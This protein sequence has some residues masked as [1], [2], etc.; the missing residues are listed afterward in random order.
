MQESARLFALLI[1]SLLVSCGGETPRPNVILV[2]VDDLGWADLSVYGSAYHETP[3]IDRLAEGGI[4]FTQAYAAAAV[5]SPSRAA[6]LTGRYP[7]RLGITD[8]IR[9]Q[10]QSTAVPPGEMPEPFVAHPSRK[11]RCP[12]NYPRLKLEEVT[13]AELMKEAGYT[14]AHIGKWHLG[15]EEWYPDDQGFDENYGG[16]DYGQ[17]PSYFDPYY[18]EGHGTI[19]TLP[20]RKEGEYLTDREA[21]EAVGFITKNADR[22]FFLYLAHY[23]VHTPIQAKPDVEAYYEGKPKTHQDNAAYAAMVQSVDDA[24]G[25]VLAALDSLGLSDDTL[26]LFTSDNGGLERVTDNAPLRDGKGSPYEGGIRVPLIARYPGVIEEGGESAFPAS[27]IDYLPTLVDLLS[28]NPPDA[29]I[30][31]T[32]L[33]PI[34]AGGTRPGR[35]QLLWHFP[36]YRGQQVGPYSI[37]RSGDWKMIRFYDAEPWGVD[38]IELFDL[39]ADPY[40]TTNVADVHRDLVSELEVQLDSLLENM[41]ARMPEPNPDYE[42]SEEPT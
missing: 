11:L 10:F 34:L 20:G 30:D 37:L 18:R 6:L 15:T 33:A 39:E 9:A 22:P 19:P 25:R 1:A 5:C 38:R 21:D 41:G 23:A 42:L 2:H 4:R 26:I 36:H 8:W 16:C 32:S 40:E 31:G 17:P 13:I 12:S 14:T 3:H 7:A 27:S 24:M 28:L 29:V 35:Q